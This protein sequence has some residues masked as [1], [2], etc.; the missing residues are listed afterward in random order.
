MAQLSSTAR[1]I[2][3]ICYDITGNMLT[4]SDVGT[5][6]Y[7][8]G[9]AGPHAVAN[10]GGDSYTYD[11]AGNM[12][13]GGGRSVTYNT[14]RKPT[15]LVK[16]GHTTSFEYGP[17]RARYKRVDSDG[18]TTKTTLYVGNVE[19]ISHSSGVAE[20]KRYISDVAVVTESSASGHS[21]HYTHKDSLG[22]TDVVTDSLG[23]VV[24]EMS[25]DAFGK[26]WNLLTLADL[27]SGDYGALNDFTTR[28][29]TGHEM[30]DEVGVIHMNGRVYDPMLGRFMSADP[31]ISDLSN[32]QRLNRYSYV[33]NSPLSY[34]DPSGFDGL[35]SNCPIANCLG[36]RGFTLQD[37]SGD[38]AAYLLNIG[39]SKGLAELDRLVTQLNQSSFE[40]IAPSITEAIESYCTA[41]STSAACDS[42]D[43]EP[44][45]V[46]SPESNPSVD[47]EPDPEP[48][49][50]PQPG[51]NSNSGP[52]PGRDPG[53]S[54]IPVWDPPSVVSPL[55]T[56]VVVGDQPNQ[57]ASFGIPN[58]SYIGGMISSAS[59]EGAVFRMQF[60]AGI[61]GN[62]IGLADF[63][64]ALG[65]FNSP[66]PSFNDWLGAE[67]FSTVTIAGGASSLRLAFYIR[68]ANPRGSRNAFVV[69]LAGTGG[70]SIGRGI[71]QLFSDKTGSSLGD[72]WRREITG[73]RK[74]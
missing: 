13:T 72:Y 9:G 71:D 69:F 54:Q 66:Y 56:D 59:A 36:D 65:I 44:P 62:L 58:F 27:L 48:D 63:S 50:N 17:D 67:A 64:E 26:R 8:A 12:L 39:I 30:L 29:F 43:L 61:V 1:Q 38:W 10:A 22:S 46:S 18:T 51:P 34:T 32:V 60:A 28:G 35:V 20:T 14:F 23:S 70:M 11:A 5:Y 33:L 45:P 2:G 42:V 15:Q 21:E 68:E 40:D 7:G 3:S 25:F 37:S 4:K 57:H 19:F 41:N 31:I 74:N 73:W 24:A 52:N 55:Q 47:P 49:A 53:G 6:T 16:D